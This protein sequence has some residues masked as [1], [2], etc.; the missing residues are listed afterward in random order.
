MGHDK[1]LLGP[2]DQPLASRVA[3]ALRAVG[4]AEVLLVGGDGGALS[5]HGDVWLADDRPGEGP[6]AAIA[7]AAS[8]RPGRSLLVCSCDLPSVTGAD[9][10]PLVDALDGG[11]PAAVVEVD[12][13]SQWSVVALSAG[14]ATAVVASVAAGER[15]LHRVLVDRALVLTTDQPDGLRDADRPTDLPPDLRPG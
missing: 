4:V 6:L 1:A 12:G 8:A 15:A 3:T 14:T 13:R 11:A 9:L 2:T 7:T 5:A 10:R